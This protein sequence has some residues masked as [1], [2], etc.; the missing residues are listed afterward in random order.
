MTLAHPNAP[1]RSS[2]ATEAPIAGSHE[3]ENTERA[4][5]D[6][7]RSGDWM[8]AEQLREAALKALE[9]GQDVTL[10][11]NLVN[12]LDASALQVLLAFQIEQR[13]RGRQLQL[14]NVSAQL[15]QWFGYSGAVDQFLMFAQEDNG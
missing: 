10:N 9:A 8:S 4:V 11:L 2:D 14:L 1:Q 5:L 12:Y 7:N 13:K 15:R 6:V 3:E